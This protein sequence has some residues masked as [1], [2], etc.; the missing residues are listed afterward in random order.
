VLGQ[1]GVAAVVELHAGFKAAHVPHITSMCTRSKAV[2]KLGD[3]QCS[4]SSSTADT[5]QRIASMPAS[6]QHVLPMWIYCVYAAATHSAP[7]A[8]LLPTA[9]RRWQLQQQSVQQEQQGLSKAAHPRAHPSSH[10]AAMAAATTSATAPR[11]GKL[12]RHQHRV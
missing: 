12:W 8:A 2:L 1:Q 5:A 7:S 6:R 4:S 9:G 11:S 10:P 3:R